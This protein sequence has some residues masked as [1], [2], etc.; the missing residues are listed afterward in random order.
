MT[1]ITEDIAISGSRFVQANNGDITLNQNS[2]EMLI[3]RNGVVLV[4][5]DRNGFVYSEKDGTRRILIGA[6]PVDGHVI[7]ALSKEGVDVIEELKSV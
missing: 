3:K 6:S 4:R 2:G 7:Q 1:K 5:I